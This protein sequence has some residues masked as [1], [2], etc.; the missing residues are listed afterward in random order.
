MPASGL[1]EALGVG[2]RSQYWPCKLQ[3]SLVEWVEKVAGML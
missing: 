2:H 1:P 3:V